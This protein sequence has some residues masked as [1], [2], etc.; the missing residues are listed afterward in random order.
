MLTAVFENKY[1]IF[2]FIINTNCI[3][4]TGATD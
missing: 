2:S 1:N 3:D 4:N